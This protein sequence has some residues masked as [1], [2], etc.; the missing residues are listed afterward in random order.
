MK[1]MIMTKPALDSNVL[2]YRH[3]EDEPG[4]KQIAIELSMSPHIVSGQVVSEYL[5]VLHKRMRLAKDQIFANFAIWM[6]FST[7]KPVTKDTIALAGTLAHQYDFQLFDSIIVAASLE[8]NCDTLYSE[9]MQA[10]L[11][12][13]TKAT[14]R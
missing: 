5:N 12:G 11:T 6:R 7:L 1:Q 3:S 14:H 2:I 10:W 8:S 4:K 9:D 13:G